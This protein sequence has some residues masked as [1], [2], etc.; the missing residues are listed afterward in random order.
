MVS[1]L[2]SRLSGL[3]LSTGRGSALCSLA[4]RFTLIVPLSAQVHEWVPVN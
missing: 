2:D 3:G 4:R 1:M